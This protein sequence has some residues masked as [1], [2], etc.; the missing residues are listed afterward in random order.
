M[1]LASDANGRWAA[2]SRTWLPDELSFSLNNPVQLICGDGSCLGVLQSLQCQRIGDPVLTLNFAVQSVGAANFFFDTGELVFPQIDVPVAF[3]TAA[4][5]LT[6]GP[7]GATFTGQ[8]NGGKA[9]EA[10][11]NGGTVFADL[12]DSFNA[13]PNASATESERFPAADF[14]PIG[15][16]VTSM[17]AQWSFQLGPDDGASGTSRY[18]IQ[19]IPDAGTLA[20]A[21]SG[22]P[23]LAGLAIR[24]RRKA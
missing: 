9:Y 19:P 13:P 24:R 11:Y 1:V 20:L 10:T 15:V 17:R 4:A 2:W 18:E 7:D 6:A 14:A 5:T 12:I 8:F 23:L 16:P 21:L 3:A 22:A